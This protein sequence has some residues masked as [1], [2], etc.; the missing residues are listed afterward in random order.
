LS[1]YLL[2]AQA[3]DPLSEVKKKYDNKDF[4]GAKTDL[5][6]IINAESKNKK[7]II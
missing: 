3:A 1:P 5:S 7:A 4:A 2:S 6:K